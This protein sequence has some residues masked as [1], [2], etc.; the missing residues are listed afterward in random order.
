VEQQVMLEQLG[1]ETLK[2]AWPLEAIDKIFTI[3]NDQALA[4]FTENV[5]NG[6]CYMMQCIQAVCQPII[7]AKL[8]INRSSSDRLLSPYSL[9]LHSARS[10]LHI[11]QLP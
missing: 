7:A 8:F 11:S 5:H 10:A 6:L 4:Q 3:F 9:L 2:N 1:A